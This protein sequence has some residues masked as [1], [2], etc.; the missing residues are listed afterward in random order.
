ME[1]YMSLWKCK[2]FI[3]YPF[4]FYSHDPSY[5]HWSGFDSW[6]SWSCLTDQVMRI[7]RRWVPV[8]WDDTLYCRY[9]GFES[10]HVAQYGPDINRCLYF[11]HSI[12][13]IILWTFGLK[14]FSFLHLLSSPLFDHLKPYKG[15][16]PTAIILFK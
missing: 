11:V 5:F 12:E 3:K 10:S 8:L 1:N 14:C 16:V 15:F 2:L 13:S 9:H 6:L 7:N 4:H